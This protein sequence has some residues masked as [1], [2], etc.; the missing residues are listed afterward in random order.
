VGATADITLFTPIGSF[1]ITKASISSG[2]KNSLFIGHALPGKV[3]GVIAQ[4]KS[5]VYNA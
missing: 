5:Q 1:E 2:S 3:Y 4:G